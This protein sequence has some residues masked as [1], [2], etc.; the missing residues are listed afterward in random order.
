M[1]CGRGRSRAVRASRDEAFDKPVETMGVADSGHLLLEAG[2]EDVGSLDRRLHECADDRAER[3]PRTDVLRGATVC[4]GWSPGCRV[5][6]EC[7]DVGNVS[8]PFLRR[9][10]KVGPGSERCSVGG[11][12]NEVGEVHGELLV[13]GEAV[14]PAQDELEESV[15]IETCQQ[16]VA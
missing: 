5:M 3:L 14:S 11:L 9:L 7:A 13:V 1:R 8:S 10:R 4:T 2:V 6:R 15:G 16:V 12:S